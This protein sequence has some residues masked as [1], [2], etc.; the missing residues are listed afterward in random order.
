MK[1]QQVLAGAKAGVPIVFGFV[2]V[3]IA[4]AVM[5]QQ[6]GF[7][8]G[9]TVLMSATVF[10]GASQ[11]MA[12][13][14]FGKGAG[15]AAIILATFMM[16]LR[17]VIMST[18]VFNRM[19][20]A[21]LPLR[22][23]AAFG[24]TDESFGCF[25]TLEKERCTIWFFLGLIT[26]TYSSWVGGTALGVLFSSF[27]PPIISASLGI[28]LYALF[29]GILAPNLGGNVRLVMLVLLAGGMNALLCRV[30]DSSWALIA[31]TLASACFGLFFVED[32]DLA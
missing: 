23:L 17:H 24:L 32:T 9:E 25:T 30:M 5:A 29:I 2:P 26:V 4:F 21:P 6:A 18:C 11:I 20:N 3:A 13:G 31:A 8:G 16:N 1:R 22:L 27:L 15:I 14:M 12:A 10:A 28:A 19:Q 7:R